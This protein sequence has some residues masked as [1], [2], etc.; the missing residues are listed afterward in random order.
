[1]SAHTQGPWYW[2]SWGKYRVAG[3]NS[4]HHVYA[5]VPVSED[6]EAD[7]RLIAAAPE[8]LHAL[9]EAE[10]ALADYVPTIEKTG[11]SLN[12]GHSVIRLARAAIKKATE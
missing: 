10:N 9:I 8:L 11:A 2:A 4:V 5:D 3:L 6:A 7:A 12:Y 1:M